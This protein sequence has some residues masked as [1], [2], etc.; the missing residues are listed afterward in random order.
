MGLTILTTK[1][2]AYSVTPA[3]IG[4]QAFSITVIF[5][6]L[7]SPVAAATWSACGSRAQCPVL[8]DAQG[9][10]RLLSTSRVQTVEWLGGPRPPASL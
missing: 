9:S 4:C 7:D 10:G 1:T 6:L 5:L 3:G 2:L 8:R